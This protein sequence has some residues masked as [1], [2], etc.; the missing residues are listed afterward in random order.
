MRAEPLTRFAIARVRGCHE[1]PIRRRVIHPF[2]VHEL[3]DDHVVP[4]PV[5]H[6]DEPPVEADVTV[7]AAGTPARALIAN[8]DSGDTQAMP[9]GEFLQ[10]TW[11]FGARLRLESLSILERE[12]SLRQSRAL[13]QHPVEMTS[14]KGI[15]LAPR[16][17]AWDG[18]AHAPVVFDAQQIPPGAQMAHEI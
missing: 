3:V 6:D 12:A 8:A 9:F 14:R 11:K 1:P 4:H 2:E 10:A 18:D 15:G 7:A 16:S 5:G 13:T 17:P